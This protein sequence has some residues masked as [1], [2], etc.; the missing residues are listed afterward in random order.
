MNNLYKPPKFDME[1][2]YAFLLQVGVNSFGRVQYETNAQQEL[3][4]HG[5]LDEVLW[6]KDLSV[7]KNI[8]EHCR[9]SHL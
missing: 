3:N 8:R 6:G 4:K 9:T 2:R 5:A 7:P 1:S